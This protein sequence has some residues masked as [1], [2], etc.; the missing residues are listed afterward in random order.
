MNI[1]Y[2]TKGVGDV[3][4]VQLVPNTFEEVQLKQK[5]TLR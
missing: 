2:N 3:L 1:F 5:V 4:L